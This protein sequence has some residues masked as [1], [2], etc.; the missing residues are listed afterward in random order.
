[1]SRHLEREAMTR[2]SRK[3]GATATRPSNAKS[4][5]L[6]RAIAFSHLSRNS[7]FSYLSFEHSGFPQISQP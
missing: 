4:Q 6:H 2:E 1:M 5:Q 3:I 7:Q